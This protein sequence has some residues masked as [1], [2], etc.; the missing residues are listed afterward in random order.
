MESLAETR[1]RGQ[2]STKELLAGTRLEALQ[3]PELPSHFAS[4]LKSTRTN[5]PSSYTR[6]RDL[7]FQTSPLLLKWSFQHKSPSELT[8]RLDSGWAKSSDIAA[9]CQSKKAKHL[10]FRGHF[11]LCILLP[12]DPLTKPLAHLL[13]KKNFARSH[14]HVHSWPS[15]WQCLGQ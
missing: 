13:S 10:T 9:V 1:Q 4:F 14:W 7:P 6:N 8:E 3:S 5:S 15:R 2:P 11:P 12:K